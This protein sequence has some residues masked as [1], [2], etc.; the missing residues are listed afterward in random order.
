MMQASALLQKA[1]H[2]ILLKTITQRALL[3][4]WSFKICRTTLLNNIKFVFDF[5]ALKFGKGQSGT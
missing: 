1:A 3:Q 2:L 5:E 4:F